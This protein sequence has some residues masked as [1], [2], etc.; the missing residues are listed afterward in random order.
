LAIH[1]WER[2]LSSYFVPQKTPSLRPAG[3]RAKLALNR[4]IAAI[5]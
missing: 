3:R 4:K 1:V 2:D 5:N